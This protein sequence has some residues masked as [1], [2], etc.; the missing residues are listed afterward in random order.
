MG[1][2]VPVPRAS[3]AWQHAFNGVT[4][5]ATLAFQN[6][7]ATFIVAGV[8][9]ARDSLLTEAGVDLHINRNAT[10]GSHMSA[11]PPATSRIRPPRAS[12]PGSS[13]QDTLALVWSVCAQI[14]TVPCRAHP[15]SSGVSLLFAEAPR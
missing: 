4:P 1:D 7:G 5:A 11:S 10:V 12:S 3:A 6:S 15:N 9:I 2:M 14:Y 8:P 13:D